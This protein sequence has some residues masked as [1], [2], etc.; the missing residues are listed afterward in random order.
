MKLWWCSFPMVV[1]MYIVNT[2]NQNVYKSFVSLLVVLTYGWLVYVYDCIVMVLHSIY[3][4]FFQTFSYMYGNIFTFFLVVKIF[5]QSPPS[6]NYRGTIFIIYCIVK[7]YNC[8]IL[9]FLF[10]FWSWWLPCEIIHQI[11]QD[12]RKFKNI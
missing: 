3:F 4:C 2:Q 1:F 12:S 6:Q 5:L 11:M 10:H 7:V 9:F 8:E